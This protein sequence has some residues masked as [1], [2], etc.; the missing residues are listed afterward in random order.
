MFVEHVSRTSNLK[1]AFSYHHGRALRKLHAATIPK[2]LQRM[3]AAART[4][5]MMGEWCSQ[6]YVPTG[7]IVGDRA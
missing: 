5:V 6:F 2:W 1:V 4:G 3:A 7:K